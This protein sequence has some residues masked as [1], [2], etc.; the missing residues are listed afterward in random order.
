[1]CPLEEREDA[2]VTV[3]PLVIL[4]SGEV[5]EP[6]TRGGGGGGGGGGGCVRN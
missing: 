4:G 6:F 1:M 5:S 3:V 2:E